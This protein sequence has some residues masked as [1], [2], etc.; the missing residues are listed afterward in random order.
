MIDLSSPGRV[1]GRRGAKIAS[2]EE[3]GLLLVDKTGQVPY[4]R[5]RRPP[6]DIECHF[7]N[8]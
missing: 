8:H 6:D 7:S 5:I 2:L 4:G 1:N 3:S